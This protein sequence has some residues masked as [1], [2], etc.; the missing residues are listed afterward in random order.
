LQ[1]DFLIL[2]LATFRISALIADEEGPFGAIDK[3]RYLCGV[4]KDENGSVYGLNNFA[5]G[6]ICKWCN[7]IWIGII[8]TMAYV[9]SKEVAV[10]FCLPF[11]LSAIAIG[12]SRWVDG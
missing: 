1:M 11:A 3:L 2:A 9:S 12:A 6:L 8:L 4:R 10:L 5:T 7:S